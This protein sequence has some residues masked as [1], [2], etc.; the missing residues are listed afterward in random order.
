MSQYFHNI[1][2]SVITLWDGLRV[3]F[4]HFVDKKKLNATLQYPHEKWPI[5]ERSIGFV[6]KDYNVIRSRLHVDINDCIGCLQCERV[7]PVNCIKIETV[8][9]PKDADLG[10]LPGGTQTGTTSS[11]TAKRLLVAR[12]DIDMAE[13]CY[14]NLCV[15]PCPEDCIYMTG[16]PN[17]HKHPIDY[18]F[19]ERNREDLVYHFATTTDE[20]VARLAEIMGVPNPRVKR[21]ERLEQLRH[22]AKAGGVAGAEEPGAVATKPEP[23]PKQARTEPAMD[24]SALAA[25]ED[26]ITRSLAKKAVAGA[27][28][29][30]RDSSGVAK[31]VKAALEEAGKLT[32]DVAAI[33]AGLAGVPV[34]KPGETGEAA[35]AKPAEAPVKRDGEEQVDLSV[36]NGITDRMARS[37]AKAILNRVTRSGGTPEEAVAEI[38]AA[39]AGMGKMTEE[40][41]AVLAQLES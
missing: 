28:R 34:R 8:K 6:E 30:G 38:R 39:L 33:V 25:I 3:T 22:A 32:P 35:E 13:C 27:L 4:G 17:G 41:E 1:S 20:E 14:C 29:A 7:C 24:T 23:K 26:R 9:A 18:E 40:I 5:P 15:Y 11:G 10:A 21:R 37:K 31:A 2:Q 19:S 36:L 16:G 12:F